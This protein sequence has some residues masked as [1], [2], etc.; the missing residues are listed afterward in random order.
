[1]PSLND[2]QHIVLEDMSWGFYERLLKEIGDRP[3]R[4]T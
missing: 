2:V 4:V 1:M 3:I